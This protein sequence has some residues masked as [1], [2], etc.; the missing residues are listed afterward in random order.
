MHKKCAL[1]TGNL[2]NYEGWAFGV[3]DQSGRLSPI[4][5]S[6]RKRIA[7]KEFTSNKSAHKKEPPMRLELMTY[8]LRKRGN[9]CVCQAASA[10][11]GDADSLVAPEVAILTN[12]KRCVEVMIPDDLSDVIGQWPRLSHEI[13]RGVLALIRSVG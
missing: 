12:D 1:Q 6:E 5:E 7:D 13:K 2:V 8:A 4:R 9:E 10:S 3:N 11:C